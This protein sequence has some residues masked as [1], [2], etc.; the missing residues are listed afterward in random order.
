M[1]QFNQ[2]WVNPSNLRLDGPEKV[3]R[4][5]AFVRAGSSNLLTSS[6]LFRQ[7]PTRARTRARTRV[8]CC[9][10]RLDKVR[11]LDNAFVYA[12]FDR[13]TCRPSV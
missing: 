2:R 3:R 5:K 4:L 6:T 1:T 8:M 13:L 10:F 11:R 9:V 7:R 12:A